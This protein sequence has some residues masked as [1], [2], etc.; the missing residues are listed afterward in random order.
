MIKKFGGFD[1]LQHKV[2][3]LTGDTEIRFESLYPDMPLVVKASKRGVEI[4]GK[5]VS[6]VLELRG[7]EDDCP[8]DLPL[9]EFAHLIA[10]AWKVHLQ[11]APKLNRS[12]LDIDL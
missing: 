1:F 11:M 6:E 8:E 12:R 5:L 7:F 3:A 9:E 10:E 4:N 2:S